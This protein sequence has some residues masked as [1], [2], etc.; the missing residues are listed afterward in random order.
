[1]RCLTRCD[2]LGMPETEF[3]RSGGLRWDDNV[4]FAIA[5]CRRAATRAQTNRSSSDTTLLWRVIQPRWRTYFTKFRYAC[6]EVFRRRHRVQRFGITS[7]AFEWLHLHTDG[8]AL[9]MV[10]AGVGRGVG[11]P[12][13]EAESRHPSSCFRWLRC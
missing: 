13:P 7:P 9:L 1:M 10:A 6:S 4:G 2:R 11:V 5:P 12:V 3:S 8:F